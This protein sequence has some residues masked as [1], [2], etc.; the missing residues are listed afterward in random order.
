MSVFARSFASEKFAVWS[1][2]HPGNA[3]EALFGMWAPP[4]AAC[5]AGRPLRLA[6]RDGYASFYAKGQSVAK[7][8]LRGGAPR[9]E[10]HRAYVEGRRRE[11][12]TPPLEGY[13]EFSGAELA[14]AST[15]ALLAGWIDTAL[16]YASA[17]K[18]FVDDLVA[19]NAGV[20]DLE[21]GLPAGD[22]PAGE[23]VAPRMDLVV[24]QTGDDGASI[25]FWEAKCANN[26][27]LRARAPYAEEDGKRLAGPKVLGQI[28][29]YVRWI[30]GGREVAVAS[31]YRQVAIEFL[32]LHRAFGGSDELECL[33]I[34]RA[35][36][37]T[38]MPRV[39]VRPG[40]VIGNYWPEGSPEGIASGRMRQCA[41]SFARNGHRAE[42]E[43]HHV[44]VHEVGPIGEVEN[45]RGPDL[46]VLPLAAEAMA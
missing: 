45:N 21:M 8:S 26:P 4:G 38:K 33:G 6:L 11:H 22:A 13:V 12:G 39:V 10:V 18:R 41:Q 16:S 29:K 44:T 42:L 9:L 34:W 40:V 20:L 35:I 14:A 19:A 28:A 3:V 17:E 24:A 36:S 43:S 15:T 37:A 2:A 23:R 32:A 25:A 7:L 27:E 31:A 5:T 1:R 46:P 30:E